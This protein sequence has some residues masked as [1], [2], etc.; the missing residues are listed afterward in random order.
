MAGIS[1]ASHSRETHRS[2]IPIRRL[3]L[4]PL[5]SHQNRS[6]RRY[7]CF[8]VFEEGYVRPY[9]ITLEENGVNGFFFL[10]ARSSL[11]T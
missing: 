3:P 6:R 5:G 10:A 9:Y 2:N 11:F 8:F 4:V 7:S 1:S